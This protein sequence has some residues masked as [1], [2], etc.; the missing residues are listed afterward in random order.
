MDLMTKRV[1][2]CSLPPA[3][4]EYGVPKNLSDLIMSCLHVDPEHRP[5]N[6]DE[7]AAGLKKCLNGKTWTQEDSRKWWAENDPLGEKETPEEA[8]A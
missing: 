1:C 5:E 6:M 4:E 8:P 3:P 2:E 7:L